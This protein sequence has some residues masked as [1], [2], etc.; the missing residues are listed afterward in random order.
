MSK[1]NYCHCEYPLFCPIC[2]KEFSP[3]EISD[4]PDNLLL[5]DTQPVTMADVNR[6]GLRKILM[7]FLGK[8]EIFE[9]GNKRVNEAVVDNFIKT[10]DN[11]QAEA[12][13]DYRKNG[14]KT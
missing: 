10:L 3:V 2:G 6:P 5:I 9:F 4:L 1:D 7:D 13:E 8:L 14:R 11:K 12:D